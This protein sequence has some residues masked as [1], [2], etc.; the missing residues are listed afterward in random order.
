[1]YILHVYKSYKFIRARL[2]ACPLHRRCVLQEGQ[3]CEHCTWSRAMNMFTGSNWPEKR[4][5]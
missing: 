1:V 3:N 4:W 2:C 5:Y